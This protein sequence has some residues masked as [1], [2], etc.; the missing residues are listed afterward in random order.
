MSD[1]VYIETNFIMA[2]ASGRDS[3]A[4]AFLSNPSTQITLLMPS[5][6]YMEALIAF[7]AEKKR[8]QIFNESLALEINEARRNLSSESA[9]SVGLY[10]EQASIASDNL[11]NEL[12]INFLKV[13][14]LIANQVEL[15]HPQ[16]DSIIKTFKEPIFYKQK[17]LRDDFILQCILSHS[18]ENLQNRKFFV[19]GNTKQFNQSRVQNILRESEI[20]YFS[21]TQNLLQ[22]LNV[23]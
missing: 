22:W 3:Q 5:I 14:E 21:N 18:K 8:R 1:L 9:K 13:M 4:E 10:L 20:I 7:E 23:N 11:F 6:C 19:S 15:I 12:Q 17:E 16:K 2:I